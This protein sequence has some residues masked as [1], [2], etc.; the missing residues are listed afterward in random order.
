MTGAS[1]A[2]LILLAAMA[3]AI[4]IASRPGFRWTFLSGSMM[5][6]LLYAVHLAIGFVAFL[7]LA[8]AAPETAGYLGLAL[9]GWM[10][11]GALD[12]IRLVPRT[13]EPPRILMVPGAADIICL[14]VMAV[15]LALAWR[16]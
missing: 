14:I 13:R 15:G 11:L 7:V 9:L 2:L 10:G 3:A 16:G 8:E 5:S 1:I 4:R 12:L 6:I